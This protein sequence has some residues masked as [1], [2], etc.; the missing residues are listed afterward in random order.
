MVE[1]VE[2]L[3]G[4]V[5]GALVVEVGGVVVGEG[6]TVEVPLELGVVDISGRGILPPTSFSTNTVLF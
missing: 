3:L 4:V 2:V 5:V 1:E 6:F